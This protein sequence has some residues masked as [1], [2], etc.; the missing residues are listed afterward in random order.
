[1]TVIGSD[2]APS[3]ASPVAGGTGPRRAPT[4]LAVLV[5]RHP[6]LAAYVVALA[7][8]AV[9]HRGIATRSLWLD[10]AWNVALAAKS[11][12]AIV[13]AGTHDQN[14]PLYNLFL[15]GWLALFGTS[16]LTLRLPSLLAAAGC[17]VL[18]LL[19][20]RR[21]YGAEASL[22]ASA[23]LLVS[24][25]QT[26]YATEGRAFALIALLCIG[27]FYLYLSLFERP[28]W[29]TA[30]ALGVVNASAL[31]VHYTIGLAWVAQGLGALLLG[32]A[33]GAR[34]ALGLY[35]ASQLLALALFAPLVTAML[36]N[37][38]GASDSW[39]PAA[40]F[41][42]LSAV[43]QELAGSRSALRAG[44]L[45]IVG[46]LVWRSARW[47]RGV[48]RGLTV[49]DRRLVVALAW[50]VVPIVL[51]YVVSQRY[52][53]L[54]VRYELYAALGWF[55]LLAALLAALP[56]PGWAR[57][58]AALLLVLWSARAAPHATTRD[59]QWHA[60][61]A[62]TRPP[63]GAPATVILVPRVECI[64]FAYYAA[65]DLLPSL[66]GPR[67]EYRDTGL[68]QRLEERGIRCRDR[69]W[70]ASD[71][72]LAAAD[73]VLVLAHLDATDTARILQDARAHGWASV[74]DPQTIAG[75][76]IHRLG[77]AAPTQPAADPPRR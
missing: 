71:L 28:R 3:S 30:I 10:E 13:V 73:V 9:K 46:F 52:P 6:A 21:F 58:V 39:L 43:V 35:V 68:E 42:M 20:V 29:S 1:M 66:F 59:P 12:A 18:L 41:T 57:T 67:G 26:T 65:P 38:P 70:R 17:A 44:L 48:A 77:R 22:Y 5:D 33:P 54:H 23:L 53:I 25:A 4:H 40:D 15:S 50:A 62:A 8:L 75:K 27:S 45:L 2:P 16:E 32:T 19:L 72:T 61:F 14:P 63:G 55:V 60:V 76:A 56:W 11:P 31:Y 7:T 34:R 51:A 64:P 36:A 49:A 74:A 24:A 69:S 37:V 47:R